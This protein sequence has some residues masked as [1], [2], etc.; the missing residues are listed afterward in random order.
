MV[1][2][3]L[4]LEIAAGCIALEGCDEDRAANMVIYL[5]RKHGNDWVRLSTINH[6]HWV[7]EWTVLGRN[8]DGAPTHI[9]CQEFD[10]GIEILTEVI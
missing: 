5:I 9:G 1:S 4:Y 6:D 7:T 2:D 10:G 3:C 8:S